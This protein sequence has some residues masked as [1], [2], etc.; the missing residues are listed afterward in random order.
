MSDDPSMSGC[1]VF[2]LKNGENTFGMNK[3]C[4]IHVN[5]LGIRK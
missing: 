2:Y 1:L 5:G 3:Q 4:D